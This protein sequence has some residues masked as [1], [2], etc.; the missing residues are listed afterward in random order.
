MLCARVS[1]V[2]NMENLQPFNPS[3]IPQSSCRLQIAFIFCSQVEELKGNTYIRHHCDKCVCYK[4]RQ[5][6]G[7][8]ILKTILHEGKAIFS[9]KQTNITKQVQWYF[10]I[11][12]RFQKT[13]EESIPDHTDTQEIPKLHK[14]NTNP[15]RGINYFKFLGNVHLFKS[16]QLTFISQNAPNILLS[17]AEISCLKRK[18]KINS[19]NKNTFIELKNNSHFPSITVNNKK[20]KFLIQRKTE[21]Q[22]LLYFFTAKQI[23]PY[24]LPL[25]TYIYRHKYT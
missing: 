8:S 12:K 19:S 3:L 5:R 20:S 9:T 25:L 2:P 1:L 21:A 22:A 24:F 18:M 11:L 10:Y 13:G 6:L 17:W 23:F 7:A 4:E 14:C 16:G 15:Y